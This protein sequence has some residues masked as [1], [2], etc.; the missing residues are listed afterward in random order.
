MIEATVL[1]RD[2]EKI[3]FTAADMIQ[4]ALFVEQQYYPY[5]KVDIVRMGTPAP[6]DETVQDEAKGAPPL[7]SPPEG[8][9]TSGLPFCD[10]RAKA[11]SEGD[12][13][14]SAA[15]AP[16]VPVAENPFNVAQ[17]GRKNQAKPAGLPSCDRADD[18]ESEEYAHESAEN[19]PTVLG[20]ENPFN[21]A[22]VGRI[23][24]GEAP[25]G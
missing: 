9:H 20:A 4:A 19:D 16:N 24:G 1:L 22:P 12:A 6:Q 21:V 7:S 8:F 3:S 25:H 18:A 13:H 17:D 14:E 10:Q 5:E 23:K 11:G 2:G 15:T